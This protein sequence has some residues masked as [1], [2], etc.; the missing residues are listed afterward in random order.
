MRFSVDRSTWRTVTL[1]DAVR[2]VNRTARDLVQHGVERVVAMEHL[3]PGELKIS[4]WSGVDSGTTFSR[5]VRPGQTLFGKRR[6]YQRKAAY[7]DFAAVCS[8]DILT[9]EADERKILP[10]FLPFLTLSDRFYEHAVGTSAGSLSPRTNWRDLADFRISL[11]GLIEQRGLAD[12]LWAVEGERSSAL[13]TIRAI[14]ELIAAVA[15]KSIADTQNR[16]MKIGDVLAVAQ[17]GSSAR[18]GDEG[19]Y[20]MLRMTNLSAGHVV[21]SDLKYTDLK[22]EEFRALRVARGDVLFNRT[23]SPDLVGRSGIFELEGDYVFASYLVRLR[24][25]ADLVLPEYLND[26]INSRCGQARIRRHLSKGVSQANISPSK[27][28]SVSIPVPSISEQ[29]RTVALLKEIRAARDS[30]LDRVSASNRLRSTI[31]AEVFEGSS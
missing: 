30:A 8:G 17:Y 28:K 13:A 27:L 24:T 18:S 3:D 20:P 2:N 14:D 15:D 22:S 16:E 23:N 21:A 12:L 7:A 4:R 25:N 31:L 19:R 26:F 5:L 29:Q 6:A 1:G 11:P 10:D 9:L